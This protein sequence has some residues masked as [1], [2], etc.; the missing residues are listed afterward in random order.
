MANRVGLVVPTFVYIVRFAV[1]KEHFGEVVGPPA[2][3]GQKER[4]EMEADGS[5]FREEGGRTSGP[6]QSA[7]PKHRMIAR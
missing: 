6:N 7:G 2:T 3:G 4:K 1:F 5:V